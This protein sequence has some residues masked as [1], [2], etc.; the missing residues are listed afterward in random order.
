[1]DAEPV[2]ADLARQSAQRLA[3]DLDVP[4]LPALTERALAQGSDLELTPMRTFDAATSIALA[5]FLLSAVQF[6][7]QVYRDLKKDREEKQEPVTPP[8]DLLLRRL[9][10]QFGE[11]Q[12]IS[13]ADR[14]RVFQVVVDEV[15]V[16]G[17]D[18]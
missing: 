10:L 7:W 2:T 8:R 3:A 6:A 13:R 9:R 1:M 12:Q 5:A 14:D 11:S 15:L 4:N 16:R 18:G 17:R